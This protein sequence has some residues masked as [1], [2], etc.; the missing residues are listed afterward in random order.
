MF[1]EPPWVTA[2]VWI[3]LIV[4]TIYLMR[5]YAWYVN[6]RTPYGDDHL[7]GHLHP[8]RHPVAAPNHQKK[9]EGGRQ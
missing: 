3:G 7:Y 8:L 2:L 9:V 1:G 5:R 4:L 6:W